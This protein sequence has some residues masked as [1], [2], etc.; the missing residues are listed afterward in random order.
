MATQKSDMLT[1]GNIAK[2]LNVSDTKI[3]K[4]I[5]QLG[6]KPVAKKGICSYY[7]KDTIKKIEPLIK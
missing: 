7:S 2:A 4:L 6:I 5:Q 3:K 1:A